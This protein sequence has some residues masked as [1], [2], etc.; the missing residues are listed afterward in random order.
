VEVVE[1][2]LGEPT[3]VDLKLGAIELAAT[4]ELDPASIRASAERWG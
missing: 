4:E 3:H 2:R 1:L